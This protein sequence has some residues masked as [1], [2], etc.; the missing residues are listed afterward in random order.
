MH[1]IQ[2]NAKVPVGL[3]PRPSDY[4]LAVLCLVVAGCSAKLPEL[5]SPLARYEE[6]VTLV[7]RPGVT[8]RVLLISP[9]AVPKG[10]FVFFPGGE[11]YLV[12][13]EDGRPREFS[14]VSFVR[15]GL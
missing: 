9:N 4:L 5:K 8:V 12:N 10:V 14:S 7:T 11:G 3:K 6:L 2:L 1:G 13:A 15:R